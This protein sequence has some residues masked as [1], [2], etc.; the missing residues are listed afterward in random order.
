MQLQG[1]DTSVTRQVPPLTCY[2]GSCCEHIPGEACG[3]E[4]SQAR[5]LHQTLLLR[6]P[7]CYSDA[8]YVFD[9]HKGTLGGG[10]N[11]GGRGSDGSMLLGGCCCSDCSVTQQPPKAG[12]PVHAVWDVNSA[13]VRRN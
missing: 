4:V 11:A 5:L 1:V 9:A 3:D 2:N 7:C 12:K 10:G 13:Y 8:R 6:G